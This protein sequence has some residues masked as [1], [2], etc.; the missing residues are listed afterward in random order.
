MIGAAV[1][2]ADDQR[3]AVGDIGH[4]RVARHRQGRMRSGERA[5]VEHLAIGGQ[6]AVE[7]VAVPGCRALLAVVDVFFGHIDPARD[8]VRL[9]YTVGPPALRN[10][11]TELDHTGAGGDAV[12]RIDAVGKLVRRGAVG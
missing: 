1:I 10:G 4:P 12:F 6:P 5:H 3:F 8:N 7:I 11:F 2:D 9:A